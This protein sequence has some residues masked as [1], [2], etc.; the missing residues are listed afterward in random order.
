VHQP[1]PIGTKKE[2]MRKKLGVW[3]IFVLICPLL[4]GLYGILHDQFTYTISP[5]YFTKFKFEQFGLGEDI[6]HSPRLGAV[7]VGWMA[8]WWTGIPIGFILGLT[9]L[10]HRDWRKAVRI[11]WQSVLLTIGITWVTGLMGLV[12]GWLYFSKQNLEWYLLEDVID[13]SNF[14]SVGS[15]HTFS[16]LGGI[17]GLIAGILYQIRTKKRLT[18]GS[19][20]GFTNQRPAQHIA[21]PQR[22]PDGKL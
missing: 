12:L 2:G 9:G 13:K 4:A 8:T 10:I 17:L 19:Y 21:K 15:M 16:Y 6:Q 1:P 5:E 14:I 20:A 18:A 11:T 22:Y 3:L 7:L